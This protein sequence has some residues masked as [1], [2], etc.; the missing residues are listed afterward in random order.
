VQAGVAGAA[1]EE[2]PQ[3]GWF[4]GVNGVPLGPIPV[5][6][7]R[8]LASAGHIDRKSLVWREGQAEWR[9]LGKFPFLARVLEEGSGAAS[10][11]LST[12]SA[13]VSPPAVRNGAA[14]ANPFAPSS[15]AASSSAASASAA[16]ASAASASAA[17][18]FTASPSTANG[19]LTASGFEAARPSEARQ[20][21]PSAWGDL[22]EEDDEEEQP[23][24]VK[25]RVSVLPPAPGGRISAPGAGGGLPPV[26]SP[27]GPKPDA[28]ALIPGPASSTGAVSVPPS[29]PDNPLGNGLGGLGNGLGSAV[30]ALPA[31]D[32]ADAKMLRD[33]GR[34]RMVM[35]AVAVAAAVALVAVMVHFLSG[36]P[37][38]KNEQAPP[39][40]LAASAEQQGQEAQEKKAEPPPA[41]TPPAPVTPE[42]S[43]E[44]HSSAPIAQIPQPPPAAVKGPTAPPSLAPS[45]SAPGA[46]AK[47]AAPSLL[48]GLNSLQTPGPTAGAKSAGTGAATGTGLDATAIQRTVRKYS[49]AVRQN[50]WQRALNARAPGVP[51]SAKVTATITVDAS[52][53]V[54][55]VS[56][57]GAPRG[58]P[59]LAHCIED[60]VRGWAFPR[61][62]G[63][64]VTN[65]PFM[66]VGQ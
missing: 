54:Q 58:Y 22:D 37:S 33:K 48:S 34:N 42:P 44:A 35:I 13:E 25:G 41:A 30:S 7:L 31:A 14:A 47:P 64:T 26:P 2:G 19:Q 62:S 40:T 4:V 53:K 39:H 5:A 16:S 65:V 59:G 32:D 45:A 66:F 49:P 15:S 38:S 6:D 36:G 10:K 57:A 43:A 55:S 46:A 61:S 18:A 20:E 11:P 50:C 27:P 1:V 17:S 24:T 29:A 21:R 63:E 51:S 56:A 28:G 12:E 52:G 8:E 23:T 3:D 60:A 9:P